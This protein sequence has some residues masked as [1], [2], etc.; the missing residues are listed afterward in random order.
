VDH[1]GAECNDKAS[2]GCNIGCAGV[3]EIEQPGRRS[4]HERA[5]DLRRVAG[6]MVSNRSHDV[7]VSFIH[8]VSILP[9]LNRPLA[10]N[11]SGVWKRSVGRGYGGG[12]ITDD[13]EQDSGLRLRFEMI[14][15]RFEVGSVD[16]ACA[17]AGARLAIL[18]LQCFSGRQL[19]QGMRRN[20]KVMIVERHGSTVRR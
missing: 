15:N 7:G 18:F 14:G 6:H 4:R 16:R 2:V 8:E 11:R 10:C 9:L 19:L 3:D 12:R 5:V 13:A 17:G 20:C 1:L